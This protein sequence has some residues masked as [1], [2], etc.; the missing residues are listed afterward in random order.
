MEPAGSE[1]EK[2]SNGKLGKNQFPSNGVAQ[3]R[4][5]KKKEIVDPNNPFSALLKLRNKL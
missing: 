3:K 2:K 4:L 1:G 5:N